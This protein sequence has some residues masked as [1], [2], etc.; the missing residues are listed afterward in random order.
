MK[1]SLKN[2]SKINPV[3]NKKTKYINIARYKYSDIMT[4]SLNKLEKYTLKINKMV[5]KK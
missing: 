4:M 2:V 5:N 1:Q 3:V